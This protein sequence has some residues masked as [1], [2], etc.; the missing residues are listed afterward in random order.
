M[1]VVLCVVHNN[2]FDSAKVLFPCSTVMTYCQA[3]S[4]R[5]VLYQCYTNARKL[6]DVPTM[7][8]FMPVL[9]STPVRDIIKVRV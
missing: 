1:K 8:A 3:H 5:A 6:V 2:D 9:E 7:K 4:M